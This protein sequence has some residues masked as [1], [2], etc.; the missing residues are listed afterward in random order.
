MRFITLLTDFGSAD[1]YVAEMKGAIYSINPAVT[2]V[3][4]AHD[5]R[6][7]DI[8]EAAF[9]L[10]QTYRSFPEGTIHVAVV[11][12]G[13]GT[14]RKGLLL[15]TKRYTFV[16]PDNGV[17]SFVWSREALVKKIDLTNPK[18]FATR[19]NRT[20][21]GRDVFGPVAAHVSLGVPARAFGCFIKTLVSLPTMRAS[22]QRGRIRGEVIHADRFGNLVTN[23][24]AEWMKGFRG[25][26]SVDGARVPFAATYGLVKE[27]A[28]LALI[29]S[30]E[31]MEI[32]VNRG[33]AAER[34]GSHAK[35]EVGNAT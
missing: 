11:D 33:S 20:F 4:V 30:A 25:T 16:G 2:V 5:I 18:Y 32:A 28:P 7:Q 21:H 15:Q 19:V 6:P 8:R 26:V 29:G 14:S 12:P 13:V 3:D 34:F 23:I 27:G 10:A 9:I 31:L 35:V 1:G 24:P 22:R 17:F